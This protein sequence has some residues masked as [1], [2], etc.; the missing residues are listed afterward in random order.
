MNRPDEE[1][2]RGDRAG[3]RQHESEAQFMNMRNVAMAAVA[4]GVAWGALA[5]ELDD[6]TLEEPKAAPKQPAAAPAKPAGIEKR[7][8]KFLAV[9]YGVSHRSNGNEGFTSLSLG[10]APPESLPYYVWFYD[11]HMGRLSKAEADRRFDSHRGNTPFS[12]ILYPAGVEPKDPTGVL[13]KAVADR[14]GYIF[15]RNRW[16]DE[17]DI[18]VG[19]LNPVRRSGGW[20]QNEYLNLRLMV[21]TALVVS[22]SP[23]V[24]VRGST[25]SYRF[26]GSRCAK[27]ATECAIS[28]LR[29]ARGLLLL[30]CDLCPVV[31]GGKT[32]E[33]ER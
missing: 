23:F 12:L 31:S 14:D 10:L 3:A 20:A 27:N 13:P 24:S 18:Q 7:L 26:I 21:I 22:P 16:Q 17:N 29:R 2:N 1:Q 15:F 33:A 19:L 4:C 28:P 6:L 30:R 9:Q 25:A 32:K 5:A 11:R 8:D